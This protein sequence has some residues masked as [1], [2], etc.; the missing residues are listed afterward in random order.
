MH[1][2]FSIGKRKIEI[3]IN[4]FENGSTVFIYEDK[5][6]FG[7]IAFAVPSLSG[8]EAMI[9]QM[10]GSTNE[11][12]T[13]ALAEYLTQK[14]KQ[15]IILSVFLSSKNDDPTILRALLQ[16]FRKMQN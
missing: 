5:R 13:R 3:E 11:I 12:T 6:R 7:T 2:Q 10:F 1:S 15:M 14:Y 8:G 4:K 9:T 16:N